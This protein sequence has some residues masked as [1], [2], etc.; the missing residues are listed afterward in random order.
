MS[1]AGTISALMDNVAGDCS[2]NP[3]SVWSTATQLTYTEAKRFL[4]Q[5]AGE[6]LQRKD[7]AATTFDA[8]FAGDGVSGSFDLPADFLRLTRDDGAV[9]ELSPNRRACTPIRTNASW[10]YLESRGAIGVGRWYRV[11]GNQI[12]FF[13]TLPD[14][15]QIVASYVTTQWIMG[16]SAKSSDW[17]SE[18]DTPMLPA[19]LL[20]L[21]TIWRWRRKKGMAYADQQIE[22]E[23]ELSRRAND[24][25]GQQVIDMNGP[26]NVGRRW[27][28][29]PN[30]IPPVT[31]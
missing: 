16:G 27:R 24:D 26:A 3:P 31:P 15:G 7:F 11:V 5:A 20:E 21:G 25:R 6:I 22:Y 29:G 19:R 1:V 4:F 2:V 28:V 8:S 23:M 14:G 12:E 9:L 17:S 13:Q 18:S 30:D 10:T